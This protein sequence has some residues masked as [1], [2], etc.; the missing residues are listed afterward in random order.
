MKFNVM[1]LTV[2]AG[3]VLIVAPGPGR[4]QAAPPARTVWTGVYT[5]QQVARGAPAF[6]EHCALCHG[7]EMAGGAGSPALIGPEFMFNWNGKSVGEL[8]VYV[9]ASMPPGQP[10][11][12]TDQQYADVVAGMLKTNGFPAGQAELAPAPDASKDVSITPSK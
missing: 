12:L 11:S 3:L 7:A 10:G 1:A 5:D 9:K 4:G 6:A 2:G 8:L